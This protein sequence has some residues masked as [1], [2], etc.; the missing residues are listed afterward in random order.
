[1]IQDSV[2]KEIFRQGAE[3]V[4]KELMQQVDMVVA[5]RQE[6]EI[7][8]TDLIGNSLVINKSLH[9][10][11]KDRT[12]ENRKN[13][14]KLIAATAYYIESEKKKSINGAPLKADLSKFHKSRLTELINAQ[15]ELSLSYS[16]LVT[17]IEFYKEINKS[18]LNQLRTIQTGST[19]SKEIA[20]LKNAILIYELTDF[21]I[22][23]IE[24]FQVGGIDEIYQIRTKIFDEIKEGEK[25]DEIIAANA[26]QVSSAQEKSILEEIKSRG[27][28][29]E[30]IKKKWYD[31][32]E[33]IDGQKE[34]VN[35]SKQF[36]NPLK[37]TRDN[38]KARIGVLNLAQTTR[39]VS[40]A[41]DSVDALATGIADWE[42]PPIDERT[43]CELL[44][45]GFGD[46]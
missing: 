30:K 27:M 38:A 39:L 31:I 23:S 37:L 26:K 16:T 25:D 17:V 29:R 43:A 40:D 19:A 28:F 41:V 24:K 3:L 7:R 9:Q 5:L 22:K 10:N 34:K 20:F 33:K 8:D 2:K 1:M 44:N 36:L 46:E 18:I 21:V 45:L 6:I 4:E 32:L 35:E 42:L 12:E 13:V 15:G 14:R 11:I